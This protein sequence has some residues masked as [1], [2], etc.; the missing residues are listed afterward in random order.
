MQKLLLLLS[1]LFVWHTVQ[2]Q[3]IVYTEDFEGSLKL[4]SGGNPAWALSSTLQHGG[5]YSYRGTIVTGDTSW[6]YTDAFSTIGNTF[7]L[8][9]FSHIC[10]IEFFDAGIIEV[11]NDG[12]NTWNKLTETEYL[13]S[14]TFNALSGD[15]FTAVAYGTDWQVSNNSAT[16]TNTWWKDETFDI[17]IHAGNQAQVQIRFMLFD[18]NN[19]GANGNYG[20]LLDDIIVTAS[21]SELIAPEITMQNPIIQGSVYGTGPFSIYADITDNTALDTAYIIYTVNGGIPDTV[22]MAYNGGIE[23]VGI[24]PAAV[25][26]DTICYYL[27]AIDAS[28]AANMDQEPYGSCY[29]IVLN[30]AL[31]SYCDTAP[32]NSF[33]WLET[34]DNYTDSVEEGYW[35][36][37]D[38]GDNMDWTLFS[39]STASI[40]TGPDED[41]T[42]GNG[43]YLYLE[44]SGF[45]NKTAYLITQCIDLTTLDNPSLEFWYHMYG[46]TMGSLHVDIYYAGQWVQDIMPTL[47][48]DKGNTWFKMEVDLTA[49]KNDIVL[50]RFRGTTGSNYY[51]DLAIDDV[52]VYD[53]KDNDVY[54]YDII[55]PAS[56]KCQLSAAETI[57]IVVKNLGANTQDTIPLAY[58]VNSGTIVRDTLFNTLSSSS[59]DTFSF[60]ITT[61]LSTA[62]TYSI[63][64]WTEMVTDEYIPNDTFTYQVVSGAGIAVFPATE[65]FDSF[66]KGTPGTLYND[67]TNSDEDNH[68]WYVHNYSTSTSLT[69]PD[70]DHTSGNGMYMYIEATG[71]TGDTAILQSACYDASLL[72]SPLLEFYFHMYG[73]NMGELHVDIIKN[74]I[75]YYDVMTP[76]SGDYGNNWIK[77]EVDLT[78]FAGSSFIVQF[79][80]IEGSVY[81]DMAI[82][83]ITVRNKEIND[84]AILSI[85]APFNPCGT[86][87]SDPIIITVYNAGIDAQTN[88]PVY[89]TVNGGTPV[90]DVVGGTINAGDTT[91]FI[92]STQYNFSSVGTYYITVWSA[93]STD[94]NLSN[95][96]VVEYEF[97]T[98]ASVTTF[99]YIENFD[100]F[101]K[102]S[103][104][105]YDD[106]TNETDDA[107]D[108][109]AYTA[110]TSSLTGPSAD[111]TSGTGKYVYLE[112]SSNY[113]KEA[114]LT[115]PCF[116]ISGIA[117]P[118]LEFWYHMYGSSMGELH[119]DI[120][121]N[122]GWKN[123]IMTVIKGD[124]GD[125]WFKKQIDLSAYAGSMQIR[126]RGITGSSVYSDMA[127][128]DVKIFD[129]PK[130]DVGVLS[131][132][133]TQVA[134]DFTV[135]EMITVTVVN[136]GGDGQVGIPLY[137][138]INGGTPVSGN[139][140]TYL[141]SDDTL[142][143]T[144]TTGANFNAEGDYYVSA[145]TGLPGDTSTA[146]DSVVDFLV[147]SYEPFTGFPFLETFESFSKST[148]TLMKNGW[149]NDPDDNEEWRVN[150]G[151]SSIYSTGPSYDHTTGAGKYVYINSD[152]AYGSTQ[153]NLISP[154]IDVTALSTPSLGFWYHM[155]GTSMGTLYVDI[156]YNGV[157]TNSVTSIS[158]NKGDNWLYK[159]VSLTSYP[160][161]I[162]VRF[163][164][165]P[166]NSAYYTDM[167]I[168]D[169]SVLPSISIGSDSL[170]A[171]SQTYGFPLADTTLFYVRLINSGRTNLTKA[172]VTLSID[173]NQI[174]TEAVTLSPAL[175]EM[176]T[177]T[178]ALKTK[179]YLG[180]GLHDICV[181]SSEPNLTTDGFT[182]DDTI[183]IQ[184]T[185]FDNVTSYPYC[186]NFDSGLNEW[187]PINAYNYK[188]GNTSWESGTPNKTYITSAYSGSTAWVTDT[189]SNYLSLDSSGLFTP[190]FE[191][192]PNQCYQLSFYHNF[193]TEQFQDGGVV[194]YSGNGGLNWSILG[195]AFET[196]W[197]NSDYVSALNPIDPTAGWTGNSGG[198]VYAE[199]DF[200]SDSSD[201]IL[202]RFRFGSDVSVQYDGWAIDDFC[203]EEV[204][205]PCNFSEIKEVVNTTL[206]LYDAVP[207]P[208]KE[209][210]RISYYLPTANEITLCVTNVIGEIVYSQTVYADQ[211][212]HSVDL[213]VK[214]WSEGIY[215]Y[216]L[217]SDKQ[218]AVKK[219]VVIK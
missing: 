213:D 62:G 81:S 119:V 70:E 17:S 14:G 43:N 63:L 47:S 37:A 198:W 101:V 103:T 90:S 162:Q 187:V 44:A 148:P 199:H 159:E 128:D 196:N 214:D 219:L 192:V 3:T 188:T 99:P 178:Y 91:T 65:N 28:L 31:P 56:S 186:N 134:C 144:F 209:K 118:T 58:Q 150:S 82:D 174:G 121:Y 212:S 122:G 11:S 109:M 27:E 190:I 136:Y 80:G 1:F 45:T 197:M 54:I 205:T 126:F 206:Y 25:V 218:K 5:T 50:I 127:I 140:T 113:N 51:S 158:G 183:C 33:V 66:V 202:F 207:N 88:I 111:H 105:M 139:I 155:Y 15:K 106:W 32:I 124:Q 19:T 147:S 69:G 177:K 169:V 8:L 49:Y 179:Y 107:M 142:T 40:N 93:L 59:L 10:K 216:Q 74:G 165:K 72:S 26:G 36:N 156:L 133:I 110:S 7:V 64:A 120:F 164:S 217:Q 20:W 116:N 176:E 189:K 13:S 39:G 96:S 154:C 23:Y 86:S 89:Y 167:A 73:S 194:E 38:S 215:Y 203:I 22:G 130:N 97:S 92:F 112:S 75:T 83:D 146:N 46:S 34:F 84:I 184:Y 108:W 115:S 60:P 172:N 4:S 166:G 123:D 185:V 29:Q 195:Q 85:D 42:T 143:Y 137:Y 35:D 163:R 208:T 95:D 161:V 175:D 181:W 18:G 153:I 170:Y 182:L 52:S 138:S 53:K 30:N 180:P 61:D 173:G 141:D 87:T 48:G 211:G 55:N 171:V 200:K 57:S 151:S 129:R 71:F 68:D 76:L 94:A 6:F 102:G 98:G 79:R 12:G 117:N 131:I 125:K 77:K 114:Y 168:D 149:Y 191:V 78:A 16:P 201:Q 145:W 210:S 104:I 204:S 193:Y 100:G 24:I 135:A 21:P 152:S 2:A 41:H 160:G 67:W 157:W 9:D 132:D